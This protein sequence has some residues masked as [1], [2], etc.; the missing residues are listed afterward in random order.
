VMQLCEDYYDQG[1]ENSNTRKGGDIKFGFGR[2]GLTVV[3][4]SNAPNNSIFPIW[5]S[6]DAS[7]TSKGFIPLFRRIDR[8]RLD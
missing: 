5:L 2:S 6:R 3:T 7:P 8:H 1:F 4:H